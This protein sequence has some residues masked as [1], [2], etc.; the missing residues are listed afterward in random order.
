M[1]TIWRFAIVEVVIFLAAAV[2]TF[3]L[4]E[5][6]IEKYGSIILYCGFGALVLGVAVEFGS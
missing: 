2:I 6:S 1:K 4:G 3:V 5:M